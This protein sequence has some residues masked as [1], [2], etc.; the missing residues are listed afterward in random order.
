MKEAV[1]LL[2]DKGGYVY[3]VDH[4]C[5]IRWAGSAIAEDAEK[6]SM[7]RGLVRLVREARAA[8]VETGG[9]AQQPG[10]AA[11]EAIDER[12]ESDEKRAASA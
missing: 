1:G 5:R 9:S 7:V 4:E 8:A 3:L 12:A 11:G 6:E 10:E 2:N